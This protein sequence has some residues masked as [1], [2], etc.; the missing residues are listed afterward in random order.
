MRNLPS[1]DLRHV[2]KPPTC[3]QKRWDTAEQVQVKLPTLIEVSVKLN[4]VANIKVL[5]IFP[6][7]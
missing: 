2:C 4:H 6:Y 3:V 5:P 7:Q 1:H